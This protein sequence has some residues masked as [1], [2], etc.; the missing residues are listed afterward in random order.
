[1]SDKDKNYNGQMILGAIVYIA[2]TAASVGILKYYVL[3]GLGLRT[4]I[5]LAPMVP[6]FWIGNNIVKYTRQQDELQQRIQLDAVVFS[7]VVTAL[8]TSAYGFM[9]GVGYPELDTV[10]IMPMLAVFWVVGQILSRRRYL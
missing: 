4:L 5:A 7:A 1:M 10:W 2:V 8:L 9:E 3:D 6:V